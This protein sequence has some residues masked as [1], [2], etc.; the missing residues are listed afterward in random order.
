MG[1]HSPWNIVAVN[2]SWWKVCFPDHFTGSLQRISIFINVQ[3]HAS[4]NLSCPLQ[5]TSS[6]VRRWV[7]LL[8]NRKT[9]SMWITVYRWRLTTISA[10]PFIHTYYTHILNSSTE[11][12]DYLNSMKLEEVDKQC[13][14]YYVNN[15]HPTCC[16]RPDSVLQYWI[17]WSERSDAVLNHTY[18]LMFDKLYFVSPGLCVAGF[19][20]QFI[21]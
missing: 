20:T 9:C 10:P 5:R 16:I 11:W 6:T 2:I 7:L 17:T 4:G 3:G 15:P 13:S 8:G 1:C 19:M 18:Y 12:W 14:I 21:F